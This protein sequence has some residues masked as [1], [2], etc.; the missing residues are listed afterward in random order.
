MKFVVNSAFSAVLS[1][2]LASSSLAFSNSRGAKVATFRQSTITPLFMGDETDD[3]DDFFADYDPSQY[4]SFDNFGDDNGMSYG[5]GGGGGYGGG[6]GRGGRG[7]RG[8]GRGG[9]GAGARVVVE[10]HERFPG[11]FISRAKDDVLL[12]KNSTPGESVYNE[13]RIGTEVRKH[14]QTV[15]LISKSMAWDRSSSYLSPEKESSAVP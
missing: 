4:D 11:V 5:G 14:F 13:K 12:T 15:W 3:Y 7:G 9:V 6:R 1:T 8:G 2:L 10:P